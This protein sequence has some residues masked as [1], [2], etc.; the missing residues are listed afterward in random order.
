MSKSAHTRQ[1]AKTRGCGSRLP[2][3]RAAR[4][5]AVRKATSANGD[6]VLLPGGSWRHVE[7]IRVRGLFG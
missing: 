1:R 3:R 6:W 7:T 2:S 5:A 4:P